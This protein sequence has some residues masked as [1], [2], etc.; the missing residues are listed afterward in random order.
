[1]TRGRALACSVVAWAA[2]WVLWYATTRAQHP[3]AALARTVTTSLVVAYALA[4]WLDHLAWRPRWL[5]RGR[6]GAYAAAMATT[7]VLLTGAALAVIRTAYVRALGPDPDPNGTL[8]HFAI[9]LVG[10]AVHLVI[11]SVVVRLWRRRWPDTGVA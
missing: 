10:M 3:T 7:M 1:M 9:D 6:R 11:A 2:A 4:A 5:A 8:R